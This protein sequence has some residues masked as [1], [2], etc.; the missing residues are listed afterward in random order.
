MESYGSKKHQCQKF[1]SV[2]ISEVKLH[3]MFTNEERRDML[4]IFYSSNRNSFTTAQRYLETYPERRQPGIRYFSKL[5]N[6]LAQYGAFEKPKWK[7]G[8]RISAEN[9]ENI[10][11]IVS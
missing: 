4:R 6:N 7:Y 8:S 11:E 1:A 3:I 10:L 2:A 5:D 9:R